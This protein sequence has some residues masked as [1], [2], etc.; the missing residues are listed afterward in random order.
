MNTLLIIAAALAGAAIHRIVI[1]KRI[2]DWAREKPEERT[3][4]ARLM[5][6]VIGDRAWGKSTVKRARRTGILW[7]VVAATLAALRTDAPVKRYDEKGR[8][9]VPIS[10]TRDGKLRTGTG[11]AYGPGD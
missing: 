2:N 4:D 10:H 11:T 9:I 3:L 7:I 5:L 8:P 6:F 1:R